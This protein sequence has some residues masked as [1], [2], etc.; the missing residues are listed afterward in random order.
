[1]R[2]AIQIHAITAVFIIASGPHMPFSYGILAFAALLIDLTILGFSPWSKWDAEDIETYRSTLLK[3]A[4]GAVAA[5][6]AWSFVNIGLVIAQSELIAWGKPYCLQVAGD[7]RG[8]YKPVN[9]LMDLNGLK[10]HTPFTS[11]GGSGVYQFAYHGVLVVDLGD[12]FEWRH[13]SYA[14][15]H[16]IRHNDGRGIATRGR[17]ACEPR[18]HLASQLSIW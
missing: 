4:G 12:T 1:L 2:R 9:S 17:P 10:M 13:W 8:G 15:Q 14:A 11:G 6:F 18:S 16:F 5:L 7:Y 3:V